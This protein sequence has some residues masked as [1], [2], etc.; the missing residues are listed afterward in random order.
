[1]KKVKETLNSVGCWLL[2]GI[3]ESEFA[4]II[5]AVGLI[6]YL[7]VLGIKWIYK[8]IKG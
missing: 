1:M 7:P 6:V 2:N 4:V 8:K 5:L 3:M